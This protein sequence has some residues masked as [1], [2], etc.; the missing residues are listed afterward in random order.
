MSEQTVAAI[1]SINPESLGPSTPFKYTFDY[2]DIGSV[3][4]GQICWRDVRRVSFQ[5]APS[6]AQRRL[7]DGDVLLCT[8][9]P[10]LQS[11]GRI[12]SD[13]GVPQVASTGFAVL[14]PNDPRD[15]SFIFH[16]LFSDRVACQLRAMETG[17]NY[18]AV[19]ERDVSRLTFFAPDICERCRIAAVLDAVDAAIEKTAA[20]IAKLKQVRAGLL[21]D[22]L[23]RGLDD[24]GE[25]RDPLKHPE[26][27]KDLPLGRV[28]AIWH[29]KQ[30]KNCYSVPSRNGLYKNA[31]CYG[32][33]HRMIHMPQMFKAIKADVLDAV[34]VKVDPQELQQYALIEGDLLFARR[35]LT[36]EGAGQCSMVPHLDEPVTFESSIVRVRLYQETLIPRFAVEFLRSP[37]GYL[38][39]RPFIRQVAVS[40]V[41]S[42]DIEQFCVPCPDVSE[43]ERILAVLEPHDRQIR[44]FESEKQSIEALRFGLISDLLT[45]RVRVP[46]NIETGVGS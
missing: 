3:T 41:S 7:R 8:V 15:S 9:R 30:L 27:F 37:M 2:I 43:Q 1:C 26:Q 33:G 20:V 28:P 24:N 6:R 45:G 23:T 29:V 32:Y 18:P 21:H 46:E 19:N 4:R 13:H 10:G 16:Q 12:V 25:L 38:L 39:R 11:H 35:S 42:K 44:F 5:D 36:L 31:S 40:G 17:S 14:R 22:L 34:R